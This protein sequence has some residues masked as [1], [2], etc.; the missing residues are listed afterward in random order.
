MA[1]ESNSL[2][3]QFKAHLDDFQISLEPS[4]LNYLTSMLA[5]MSMSDKA[6]DIRNATEMF[7][8]EAEVDPE[9]INQFYATLDKENVKTSSGFAFSFHILVSSLISMKDFDIS[10]GV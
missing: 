10:I 3:T 9:K 4:A 8:E 7:L 1:S 6:K 5:V 2:A